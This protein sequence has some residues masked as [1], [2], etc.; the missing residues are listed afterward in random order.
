MSNEHHNRDQKRKRALSDA[1]GT[2]S[3][4]QKS[5][6]NLRDNV[7]LRIARNGKLADSTTT[8]KPLQIFNRTNSTKRQEQIYQSNLNA[9]RAREQV[10]VYRRRN[11]SQALQAKLKTL[12]PCRRSSFVFVYALAATNIVLSLYKT[13][14][15]F[16]SD[17]IADVVGNLSLLIPIVG[18][19]LKGAS[20]LTGLAVGITIGLVFGAIQFGFSIYIFVFIRK[21][22]TLASRQVMNLAII[23]LAMLPIIELVPWVFLRLRHIQKEEKKNCRKRDEISKRVRLRGAA[24]VS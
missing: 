11:S 14:L 16:I 17:S 3:R 19:A 5:N 6:N 9:V 23:A 21:R 22:T 2:S 13:I 20:E 12:P 15:I 4:P 18:L 24:N 10:D 8:V 7:R 1:R